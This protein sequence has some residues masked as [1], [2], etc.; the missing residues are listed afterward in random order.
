MF[1]KFQEEGFAKHLNLKNEVMHC[2]ILYCMDK[3]VIL[4]LT[5]RCSGDL[6]I[7]VVQSVTDFNHGQQFI[8]QS[9]GHGLT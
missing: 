9:I 3:Y 5:R 7:C 1:Q 6:Y 8:R 2:Q 4:E